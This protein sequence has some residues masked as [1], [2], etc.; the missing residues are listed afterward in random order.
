MAIPVRIRPFPACFA[1]GNAVYL[2]CK[3]SSG[4]HFD[5]SQTKKQDHS[6]GENIMQFPKTE[7]EIRTLAQ[8]IISGLT[9]NP[10]FPSPPISPEQLQARLDKVANSSDAQVM[11]QAAAKQATD[12]KQT[13]FDDLIAD[14]KI[15]LHHAEDTV[16]GDDAKLSALGWGGRSAPHALQVP[17]QPR[18]LEVLRQGAGWLTLDWKK[19]A[20]G[21][22]PAS[23]RIE[24][25][26]L[27]NGSAWTLAG[28]AIETEATLNDQKHGK[29]WEYRIIAVNKTGE[30]EPS[31][32][33]TAVL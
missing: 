7:A 24:R 4:A 6:K 18:L 12:T 33:V 11:T 2:L 13:D 10:N 28:I 21:G 32:T 22:A 25:R 20:D 14:M 30:G 5:R 15:V 23:Y 19:P 27:T 31:N 26:E 16:H 17:G 8:N 9:N 3:I 1:A 29:E